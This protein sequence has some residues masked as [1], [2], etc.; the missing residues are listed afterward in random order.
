MDDIAYISADHYTA[1]AISKKGDL[2]IW[3]DNSFGEI[4]NSRCGN[5]IPSVSTDVVSEPYLVLKK[6]KEVWFEDYTVYAMSFQDEEYIWG[7][8]AS[9]T[10]TS[11]E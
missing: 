5:G 3:G 8:N 2:W 9:A 6:M 4:G 11:A 10:P 7:K 1:A